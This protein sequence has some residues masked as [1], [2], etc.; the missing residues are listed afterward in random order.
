MT[1][2]ELQSGHE[3]TWK[4][5]YRWVPI[6]RRL[7]HAGTQ[8]PLS[9]AANVGYRFYAHHLHTHY[10]CDWPQVRSEAA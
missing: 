6:F 10:T 1:P 7:R 3:A 8:L 5:V 2:A 4:K 9:L